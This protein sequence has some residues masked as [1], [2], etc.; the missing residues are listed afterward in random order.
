MAVENCPF[1]IEPKKE[2][3]SD[4]R[5]KDR[6]VSFEVLLNS[7]D[8]DG[9]KAT[10]EFRRLDTTELE[11]VLNFIETL[12]QAAVILDLGEGEPC[13]S[14]TKALL[15]GD[16]AKQCATITNSVIDRE[17]DS[18]ADAL[19]D[20]MLVY[21]DR[22]IALDNKEWLQQVRKPRDMSA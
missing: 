22:D 12:A 18:Y 17:K 6:F 5:R 4:T 13:F 11:D 7:D 3:E 15:A 20:L 14:L 2:S 9:L 8:E 1:S 16:P 10:H 19:E 21:M